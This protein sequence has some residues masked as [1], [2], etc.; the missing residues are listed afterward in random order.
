[1]SFFSNFQSDRCP[2]PI[3][4]NAISGLNEKVC[5]QAKKVFDAC[6]R[7]VQETDVVLTV[8]N[9]TPA[10]PTYPLTF[11]SAK[12]VGSS[13]TVSCLTIDLLPDRP[14]CARV[15]AT[16]TAPVE[17]LYTDANGVAGSGIATVTIPSDVVLYVPTPSIIPYTVEAV[18][19]I[20]AP[21]GD[22]TSGLTF[23]ATACLTVILRVVM[24]VELLIPTYGYCAIP[25]CQEYSQEAC[26]GFFELPLYPDC[27]PCT[28]NR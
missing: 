11:I 24:D 8:E 4:G 1:M 15:Q 16:V 10:N 25:P 5:I 22:Y 27:N 14:R 7:Q 23:T 2:G 18:V 17:V 9:P 6:I 3:A 26:A 19:S 12:S 28:E 21:E 13:A 20:V